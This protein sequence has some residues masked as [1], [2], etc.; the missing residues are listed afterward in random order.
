MACLRHFR[1]PKEALFRIH[2]MVNGN[3]SS[4]NVEAEAHT[5][6]NKLSI[7]P[8]G[9][10]LVLVEPKSRSNYQNVEREASVRIYGRRFKI[11]LKFNSLKWLEM[12]LT[13]IGISRGNLWV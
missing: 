2:Q 3:G 4:G 13:G 11:T 8:L 6:Q 5:N 10:A 7:R 1:L 12:N 9:G